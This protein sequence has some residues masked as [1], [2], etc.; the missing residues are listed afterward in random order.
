MS[1]LPF[2]DPDW[3]A[4]LGPELKADYM[5]ELSSFLRNEREQGRRFYPRSDRIFAAFNATPLAEVRVVIVGQDPYHGEGQAM[6]LSFSVPPTMPLPPSLRNIFKELAEDIGCGWPAS[7]DLRPWAERGVLLLNSVLTVRAGA[8]AGHA[9][10]GW[11]RFT[12]RVIEVLNERG[13]EGIVF[14][15]WGNYAKEKGTIIDRDRHHVL[16]AAHPSPLSAR[17]GFF[18]CRHFSKA[19]ELLE[20]AGREPID[21]ALPTAI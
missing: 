7:G 12:D 13:E 6:G 18:G 14:L 20:A 16:S 2:T 15:L 21:W 1:E 9:G 8:A 10:Q 3:Q 17:N 19:N 5:Q 4:A 11:E